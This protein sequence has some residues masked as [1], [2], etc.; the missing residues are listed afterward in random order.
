MLHLASADLTLDLLDPTVH[1]HLLGPRFCAG[2][3]IWQ[4]HDRLHGPRLSGPEGPEPSPDPFNG[5]GLPESFR[6][7][8]R[9]GQ[10]LTWRGLHALA[11]G[12][13]R[14]TRD[15]PTAPVRLDTPCSWEITVAPDHSQ[16]RYVTADALD[17]LGYTLERRITVND[18]RITSATRFTNTGESPFP[19]EWFAHPFF[20]L[21]FAGTTTATLP[22]GTTLPANPGFDLLPAAD[23]TAGPT[24]HFLRRFR[25]A[26]D[27]QF[28]LL[29]LP[30]GRILETTVRPPDGPAV[31]FATSFV[32]SE[33][34]VWANAHTF[35][36]EPY[37]AATLAPG[38]TLSWTLTY[39]C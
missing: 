37:L 24:L 17:D 29:A 2:G 4:V 13:G 1:R 36:V 34:P 23:P 11:P 28:M 6:H 7:Q 33:L 15:A 9:A 39:D 14:L 35:S 32:P 38:E 21:G 26:Q 18:R 25:D 8:T 22:P 12:A 5:H 30:P 20:A 19:L 27:G 31:F 16:A 10:P 3:F